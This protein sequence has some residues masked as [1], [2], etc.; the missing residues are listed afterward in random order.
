MIFLYTD[1]GSRGNPGASAAAYII[2][3]DKGNILKSDS[4]FL[5]KHTNN[6][7]EYSALLL[8]MQTVQEFAKDHQIKVVMD[9]EL[10]VR[11]LTGVYKIKDKTL[12]GFANQ[13]KQIE[14]KF[15][16]GVEYIHVTRDKNKETDNMVNE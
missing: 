3:D 10:I 9:S 14:K 1:G 15:D 8:A 16:R 2:K 7:A 5:G 4:K 12:S 6:Y 11:Q 13:I